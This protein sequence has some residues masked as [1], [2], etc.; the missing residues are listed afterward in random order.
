MLERVRPRIEL[1]PHHCEVCGTL[2]RRGVLC[3]DCADRT[4]AHAIV[5]FQ[6]LDV[7]PS[8]E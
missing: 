4:R 1:V 8:A 3:A 2:T 6:L 7:E 5:G